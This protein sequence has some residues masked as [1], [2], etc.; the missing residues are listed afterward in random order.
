[1]ILASS[2][3]TQ[4]IPLSSG[5][6]AVRNLPM[7]NRCLLVGFA[8]L[9]GLAAPARGVDLLVSNREAGTILRF[10]G[11]TGEFI[12]VFAFV[13][14]PLGMEV[15]RQGNLFVAGFGTDQLLSFDLA[16]GVQTNAV[17]LVAPSDV[18][19]GPAGE[20]YVSTGSSGGEPRVLR[21][22]GTPENPLER[23]TEDF[24]LRD[25][26]SFTF[27]TDGHLYI[28]DDGYN[29]IVRY[30]GA[31]GEF[32]DAFVD[33]SLLR[34]PVGVE[35]GPDQ[36]LYVASMESSEILRFDGATGE[37]IDIFAAGEELE[38]PSLFEF[39]PDGL[40]YVASFYTNEVLR[41]DSATGEFVDVFASRSGMRSSADIVFAEVAKPATL[42]YV[43]DFT[44][45]EVEELTTLSMMSGEVTLSALDPVGDA[46]QFRPV[47]ETNV[48]VQDID[49]LLVGHDDLQSFDFSFDAPLVLEALSI[50]LNT[51]TEEVVSL[52]WENLATGESATV[53]LPP[54]FTGTLQFP[55]GLAFAAGEPGRFVSGGAPIKV[56]LVQMSALIAGI[57]LQ[58]SSADFNHDGDVDG[59]DFL[60]W[61]RGYGTLSAADHSNGDAD[62]DGDVDAE[63]LYVWQADFGHAATDSPDGTTAVPEPSGLVIALLIFGV[64]AVC[65]RTGTGSS[66]RQT[67]NLQR[68]KTDSADS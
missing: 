27:G 16:T 64:T 48:F 17:D 6:V 21:Y 50:G 62:G 31:T 33:N 66:G 34:T 68:V 14:G 15:D 23:I 49:G 60:T 35:F 25:A 51:L 37:F 10:D 53:D 52:I 36:N 22:T 5:F 57:P 56:N 24:G 42:P 32:I 47:T 12:E 58:E 11:A 45:S 20:I 55:E 44:T 67:A 65:V 38:G 29:E 18:R 46:T 3:K 30:D 4:E 26:N 1:M 19:L 43:F 61:Q 13:D 2:N 41:Y 28:S 54:G 7:T 59:S 63:D 40:L 39:R 9:L 8:W